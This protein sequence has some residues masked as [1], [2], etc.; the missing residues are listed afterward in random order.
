[1]LLKMLQ[2]FARIASIVASI[3]LLTISIS[4][5]KLIGH[6]LRRSGDGWDILV[7]QVN[8]I[9]CDQNLR[10]LSVIL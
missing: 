7:K 10:N 9:D 8:L 5:S 4:I 3:L 2:V 1:M 6:R